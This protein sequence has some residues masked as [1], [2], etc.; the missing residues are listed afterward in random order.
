MLQNGNETAEGSQVLWKV[1]PGTA[2]AR[3]PGAWRRRIVFGLLT[4]L[5]ILCVFL[6][7]TSRLSPEAVHD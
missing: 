7:K 2:D 1:I 4:A 6:V 3:P 5:H